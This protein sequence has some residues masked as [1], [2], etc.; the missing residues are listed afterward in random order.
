[1]KV[2]VV[3][4]LNKHKEVSITGVF[5]NKEDAYKTAFYDLREEFTAYNVHIEDAELR[6]N[7]PHHARTAF[8]QLLNIFQEKD[9]K[10]QGEGVFVEEVKLIESTRKQRKKR[11]NGGLC[12]L[13]KSPKYSNRPGPPYAAG[14]CPAL[15]TKKGNDGEFYTNKQYGNKGYRKWVRKTNK[16]NTDG[17]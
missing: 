7:Q 12:K 14:S 3:F 9:I 5:K 13:L 10:F 4:Y 8:L 1:M 6:D 17:L 15:A 2:Y 16:R 11:T